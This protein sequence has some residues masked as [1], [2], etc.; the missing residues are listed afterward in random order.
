MS[1]FSQK[2]VMFGLK[3]SRGVVSLK[4]TNGFKNDIRTLM[5]FYTSR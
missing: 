1:Y 3:K 4:M 5:N 2:Y